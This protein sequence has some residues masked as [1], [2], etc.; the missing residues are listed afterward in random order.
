M[1]TKNQYEKERERIANSKRMTEKQKAE[2]HFNNWQDYI[3][4]SIPEEKRKSITMNHF[5]QMFFIRT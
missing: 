3:F 2:A 4:Y 5:N 1:K